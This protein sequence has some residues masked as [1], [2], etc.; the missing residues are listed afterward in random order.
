MNLSD[1]INSKV[2]KNIIENKNEL[3]LNSIWKVWIHSVK[4]NSW[5][6]D[7]YKCLNCTLTN[8]SDLLKLYNSFHN[9]DFKNNHVFIMREGIK[10]TWEDPKNRHGGICS[11]KT[12]LYNRAKPE[13][14]SAEV[15]KYILLKLCG[16]TLHK[17]INKANTINGL[18]L[19]PKIYSNTRRITCIIKIWNSDD[20]NDIS[21]E[22][23][24][25]II[26]MYGSLSFRYKANAPEH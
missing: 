3:K 12:D 1:S 10:P 25:D 23:S 15:F 26:N 13:F 24:E 8:V 18:S 11:I 5:N 6:D 22:M 20:N 4:N 16:E 14:S 21:N 17:D 7:D 19:S 2:E 9:F